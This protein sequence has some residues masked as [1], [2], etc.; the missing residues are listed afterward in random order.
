[1]VEQR[2]IEQNGA[3][4]SALEE[5]RATLEGEQDGLLNAVVVEAIGAGFKAELSDGLENARIALTRAEALDHL[6]SAPP[7][8]Y[9]ARRRAAITVSASRVDDVELVVEGREVAKSLRILQNFKG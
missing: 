7:V 3:D 6:V 4:I 9:V 1:M 8:D 5:T 2:A